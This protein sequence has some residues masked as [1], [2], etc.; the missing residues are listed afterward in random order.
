VPAAVPLIR[1]AASAPSAQRSAGPGLMPPVLLPGPGCTTPHGRKRVRSS[2]RSTPPAPAGAR[3][4]MFIMPSRTEATS[5]SSGIAP[6]GSP[7]AG[8]A[9]P[10]PPCARSTKGAA[11]VEA[12]AFLAGLPFDEQVRILCGA[13]KSF[14]AERP[15]DPHDPCVVQLMSEIWRATFALQLKAG[16]A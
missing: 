6:D 12:I 1:A 2:S 5:P 8:D 11:H 14:A 9:T 4:Q 13:F 10:A 7:C 3:P 15:V 16:K